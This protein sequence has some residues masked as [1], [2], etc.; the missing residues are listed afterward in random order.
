MKDRSVRTRSALS[1]SAG[2]GSQLTSAVSVDER[3][4]LGEYYGDV[5]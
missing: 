5:Y 3:D 1:A 2:V 4:F